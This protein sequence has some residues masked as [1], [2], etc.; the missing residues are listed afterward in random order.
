[1][2]LVP[3]LNFSAPNPQIDFAGSGFQV[4]TELRPWDAAGGA[5]RRA[6]VS[7]FGMG[8][9]NAH[10]VLEEPPA[11]ESSAAANDWQL[12]CLSAKTPTA[13]YAAAKNLGAYIEAH[14]ELNLAD[15]AYTLQV[16]RRE[17][18]H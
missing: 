2:V 10:A 13:L 17:F 15:A 8:G 1:K 6:G 9:T 5:P 4:N 16:G 7:S 12:L 11:V 14:P 18:A 3:S